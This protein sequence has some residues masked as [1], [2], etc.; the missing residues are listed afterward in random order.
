MDSLLNIQKKSFLFTKKNTILYLIVPSIQALSEMINAR[1]VQGRC[2][3]S[4]TQDT[5]HRPGSRYTVYA[6]ISVFWNKKTY[7]FL[8]LQH[9]LANFVKEIKQYWCYVCSYWMLINSLLVDCRMVFMMMV[10]AKLK[11]NLKFVQNWLV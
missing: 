3:R 2:G 11:S 7:I 9:Y 8:I 6:L 5:R 4:T 1:I 10:S